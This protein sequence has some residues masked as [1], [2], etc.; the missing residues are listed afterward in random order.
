MDFSRTLARRTFLHLAAGAAAMPA[1]TSLARA[2][3]Y[4]AKP[5]RWIV[6]FPPGG[7]ADTVVRIM[8]PWLAERL[9][10][11]VVVENRPGASSNISLQAVVQSPPDG[12]TL[13][14]VAAS[15][16]V[17]VSLFDLPFNLIRDIAPVSGLIDFSLVMVATPS[18]PAKT[19]AELVA[20]ARA[21]PGKITIGSFG[22]GST[23]HV[24]GELFKT[25]AGVEMVHVPYRGGA[26]MLADL[27]GGQLQVGI[28]VLT[29]PLSQIRAGGVRA[30]G[31]GS[32]TR[33]EFLPD[34]PAIGETVPG[35]EANSWCGVG[36]PRGTPPE[37]IE[38]LNR[39]IN[40]GLFDPAIKKRYQEVAT[41]PLVYSPAE[42]G[43]Y[44]AA[45][46]EKWSKVVKRAGIKP[47]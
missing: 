36:V 12:Y 18:L 13:L 35:Y 38:R 32:K 2:Q 10:Q 33:S 20:L 43:A 41:T 29:G 11:A 26:Q 27:L 14:F 9:G 47:E 7:G 5:L 22:T 25:M 23:S 8:A 3:A 39:E 16:A 1:A 17:N 40:A 30:L 44:V 19:I 31:I 21:N 45:E 4:P 24:A 28:D 15:A 37:I 42:F 46:T 34:V 6:G